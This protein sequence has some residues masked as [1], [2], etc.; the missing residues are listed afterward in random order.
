MVKLLL[1]ASVQ[2]EKTT[3]LGVTALMYAAEEG[4]TDVIDLL[5]DNGAEM[6]GKD[7]F[8]STTLVHAVRNGQIQ[9][10]KSC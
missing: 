6:Q 2:V 8:E 3:R 4:Y 5:F 10:R 7:A 1:A 9:R